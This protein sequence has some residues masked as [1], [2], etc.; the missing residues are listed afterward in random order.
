MCAVRDGLGQL[1]LGLDFAG[2]ARAAEGC[3][4]RS[5]RRQETDLEGVDFL[6]RQDRGQG[7]FHPP[8][9]AINCVFVS[10]RQH[11]KLSV[12]QS[13][14]RRRPGLRAEICVRARGGSVT[15]KRGWVPVFRGVAQTSIAPVPL[16]V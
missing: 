15:V 3:A 11:E 5:S 1:F 2:G 6:T 12:H 13:M 4:E 16:T 7:I 9:G 8:N 14:P 10:R